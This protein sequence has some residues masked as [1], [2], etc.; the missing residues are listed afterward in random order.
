[1]KSEP[2]YIDYPTVIS[3]KKGDNVTVVIRGKKYLVELTE[4]IEGVLDHETMVNILGETE[5]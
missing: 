1:M 3:F 2:V 4:D 5:K